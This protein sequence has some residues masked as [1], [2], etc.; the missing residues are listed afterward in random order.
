MKNIIMTL[1]Y[2]GT[3]YLGWQKTN[4]D[5][6]Q[7][8]VE[9]V[10]QSTLEEILQQPTPIQA[11]S[12]TDRGVHAEAQIIN[13]ILKKDIDL[14]KLQHSLNCLLPSDIRVLTAAVAEDDFHATLSAK[15][16]QYIYR[17]Y[18]G[19]VLLPHLRF[20]HW[21]VPE[22]L[23]RERMTTA[24]HVMIGEHDFIALRNHRK[25]NDYN[26]TVRTIY[27][28]D[29]DDVTPDILEIKVSGNNFLYKMCRNIVGTLVYVGLGKLSPGAVAKLLTEGARADAGITA[30]A[31][32]LTLH[33]VFYNNAFTQT[34]LT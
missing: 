8:S 7:P 30:P 4:L 10:V 16:K 3:R 28:I 1:A 2:D 24:A 12:R 6:V 33:K 34:F 32:G 29:F 9:Y 25:G 22:P 20:T 11:A 23:E 13:F 26:D 21:H 31:H 27:S 15:A 17:I 5:P 19:P 14:D 18:T